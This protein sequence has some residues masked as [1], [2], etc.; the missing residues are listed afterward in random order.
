[1]LDFFKIDSDELENTSE[2]IDVLQFVKENVGS[3]ITQDDIDD[4]YSMLDE[5]DIDKTSRLLDWQ[6]EPSLVALIAWSF[7]SDIDLDDWIKEY[8]T[9]NSMYF[10]NQKKNYLHMK[11]DLDEHLQLQEKQAV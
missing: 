5:Y 9:K 7:K 6:N 4:Y 10:I 11:K 8:F 1:M 2:E 3:D